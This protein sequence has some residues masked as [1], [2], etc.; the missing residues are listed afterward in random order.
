[1]HSRDC[2]GT[3]ALGGSAEG[4]YERGEVEAKLLDARQGGTV[5]WQRLQA[6]DERPEAD[7]GLRADSA[8]ENVTKDLGEDEGEDI[9]AQLGGQLEDIQAQ[10][11]R[12]RQKKAQK[13]AKKKG[14]SDSKGV[15]IEA[16]EG[17][18]D[19]STMSGGHGTG[20][21]DLPRQVGAHRADTRTISRAEGGDG[22]EKEDADDD[23][24]DVE[25]GQETDS[26]AQKETM[27][28]GMRVEHKMAKKQKKEFDLLD[29]KYKARRALEALCTHE[30][31]RQVTFVCDMPAGWSEQR[32]WLAERVKG[33][34]ER[35]RGRE[36]DIQTGKTGRQGESAQGRAGE[37]ESGRERGRQGEET[38][39]EGQAEKVQEERAGEE[40]TEGGQR[41]DGGGVNVTPTT[42]IRGAS[43]CK[44][45]VT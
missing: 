41:G 10:L 34:E 9:Q 1:M 5:R 29:L 27:G 25:A 31:L 43:R 21:E 39:R 3:A 15:N 13:L 19:G 14:L 30:F 37:R 18:D 4:C 35:E 40:V 7:Q 6:A 16:G 17:G 44:S 12:A 22:A 23:E 42:G 24:G 28:P 32:K 33:R 38:T 26:A 45:P 20:L 11:T 8:T 36:G 2:H